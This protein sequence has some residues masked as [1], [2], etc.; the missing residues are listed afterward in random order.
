[1]TAEILPFNPLDKKNLGASVAEAILTS[2]PHRM[3]KL[4]EFKGAGIYTLYYSGDFPL[5]QE[6]SKRNNDGD[7]N[8]PIYIGKAVPDGARKGS[9]LTA[10][11]SGKA[12][13]KRLRDHIDS[14]NAVSNLQ[15]Q[16]FHCRFLIVDDI[17]IPLGESLLI[18]RYSPVWNYLL[19]GFGNHAPGSG[20]RDSMRPKWDMVHPG[21]KWASALKERNESTEDIER[22]ITHH[23]RNTTF[24]TSTRFIVS[25]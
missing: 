1:M 3:D 11:Y 21:R 22:E 16:D 10:N 8:A 23:L 25:P 2:I 24:P 18:A 12:L 13:F 20:R 14:I 5:Y 15:I 7:F 6:I 19:D 9:S 17:W 4:E